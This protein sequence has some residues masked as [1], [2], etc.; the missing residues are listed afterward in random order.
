MSRTEPGLGCGLSSGW[1]LVLLAACS[2]PTPDSDAT[3]QAARLPQEATVRSGDL[4]VRASTVPTMTLST[5]VARQ[6][7]IARD[8]GT[9]LLLVGVRRV[10][11]EEETSVPARVNATAVDLL[12]KRQAPV[13]R[14]VR[15]G[16]FIDYVGSF[17]I[18]APET[19]RFD[20]EV[21]AD[22]GQRATLQ[23]NR[24]FFRP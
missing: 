3:R 12:G 11:G 4:L 8:A 6:Y 14:E 18:A 19:L 5:A 20:V 16:D 15:S 22:S 21:V 7:G 17:R 13:I 23:F 9:V 10:A 1:L 24:D 2:G